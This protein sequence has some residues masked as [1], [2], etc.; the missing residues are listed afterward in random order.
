MNGLPEDL[1]YQGVSIE[2]V[3][4][5]SRPTFGD[6]FL[7]CG[8]RHPKFPPT[9]AFAFDSLA[10]LQFEQ[11]DDYFGVRSLNSE[12]DDVPIWAC[13]VVGG[14]PVH[15]HPGPYDAVRLEYNVLRNP[16]RREDHFLLCVTEFAKFGVDVTYR[17]RG[18]KL[19]I[20]PDVSQI[21][22]DMDAVARH[23][24]SQGIVVGSSEALEIDF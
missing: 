9:G 4:G 7:I 14:V 23:W 11:V 24:T 3:F 20:P 21:R 13:P 15:H 10:D 1:H 6:L 19:G 18:I 16:R 5:R 22:A 12:G 2:V 8:Q 17:N